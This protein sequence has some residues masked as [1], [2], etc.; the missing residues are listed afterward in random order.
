MKSIKIQNIPSDQINY[1][2][3]LI[4]NLKNIPNSA[5]DKYT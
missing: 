1:T 5:V 3:S 2:N 4:F